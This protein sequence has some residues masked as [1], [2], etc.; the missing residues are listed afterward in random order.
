[1]CR[2]MARRLSLAALAA[3]LLVL[4]PAS[5]ARAARSAFAFLRFVRDVRAGRPASWYDGCNTH[6]CD[7]HGVCW[8]TLVFCGRARA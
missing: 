2:S 1:M 3:L 7:E 5:A 6:R 8:T 4:T